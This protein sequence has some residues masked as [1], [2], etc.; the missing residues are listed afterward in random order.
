MLAEDFTFEV[1]NE[2]HCLLDF[3]CNE[4]EINDFL[5]NDA[6]NYQKE[7]FAITYVFTKDNQVVAFFSLLND[8]LHDKGYENTVWNRFHRHNNIPN[9]K[10]I[11]Q[12]PAIKIGRLGITKNYQGTGLAYSMMDFIKGFTRLNQ[13]SASRLLLIDAYNK[14]KQLNFYKR[15]DFVLLNAIQSNTDTLS[16]YFDLKRLE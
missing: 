7:Q 15:N 3:D 8:S 9:Q 10:R 2:N 4:H 14:T 11:R 5:L 16:M 13:K 12:Y 6:L 1:L